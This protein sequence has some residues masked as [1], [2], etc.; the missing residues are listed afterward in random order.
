MKVAI[1]V[2]EGVYQLDFAG[3]MEVFTD[4]GL[5]E[6][7][8]LFEVFTVADVPGPL[9]THTGLQ[10]IPTYTTESCPHPDILVIPGGNSNLPEENPALAEW[11][12]RMVPTVDYV[13]TVCTGAIILGKLGLL[14]GLEVT[15]WHGALDRLQACAPT[16]RVCPGVRYTDNGRLL[17]T[18]GISAGIDGALHLVSRLHGR[19]V[20]RRTAE[21]MD[22]EYWKGD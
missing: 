8:P 14:E 16:A 4:A 2:Y 19:D 21:Y 12:K 18:A 7:A 6:D 1:V 5:D 9:R 20:A 10:I 11:L 3:P 13:M 17:T 15:T 22:Y